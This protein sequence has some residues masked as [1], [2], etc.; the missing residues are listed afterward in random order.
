MSSEN[1]GG[2]GGGGR[3]PGQLDLGAVIQHHLRQGQL[4]EQDQE[5]EAGG[6][7]QRDLDRSSAGFRLHLGAPPGGKVGHLQP[8][9]LCLSILGCSLDKLQ[10]VRPDTFCQA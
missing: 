10:V 6:G 9:Y 7:K 8:I 1:G 4:L 3:G 2:L 5:G